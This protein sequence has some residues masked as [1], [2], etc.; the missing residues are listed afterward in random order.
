MFPTS[1]LSLWPSVAT[2]PSQPRCPGSPSPVAS[3]QV[4][5]LTLHPCP[6]TPAYALLHL[7]TPS[8]CSLI[9]TYWPMTDTPAYQTVQ[10]ITSGAFSGPGLNATVTGG[11]SFASTL[12]NGTVQSAFDT[13]YGMTSSNEPFLVQVSGIGE[14]QQQAAR[15]V[16]PCLVCHSSRTPVANKFSTDDRSRWEREGLG[17]RVLACYH[18]A[19][20]G[21]DK[22]D[23]E[24]VFCWP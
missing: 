12:S 14:R 20:C 5:H 9:P 21:S 11:L 3:V 4:R 17:G 8:T 13:L 10:A 7:I 18:Q 24:C 15:I 19:E 16:S 2:S 22:C 6:W 23:C 1:P